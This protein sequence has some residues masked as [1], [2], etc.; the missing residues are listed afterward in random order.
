MIKVSVIVPVYNVEAYLSKCLETLVNQTLQEIEIIVVNDGTKDNSQAVIDSFVSKYN[1]VISLI[2]EN[3]GLS[4]ARNYGMQHAR[5]EYIGFVDSD[6]YTDTDMYEILYRKA[7]EREYDVVE[8]NLHHVYEDGSIDTEIGEHIIESKELLMRGRSVV[9]NKIYR[10]DWL[11]QTR[12]TFPKG[13]IYEDVEFFG[14]LVPH[15]RSY[16]YVEQAS[17]Y[18]V[19]RSNSINNKQTRK[20]MQIIDILEHIRSYYHDIHVYDEYKEAL[21]YLYAR[22]LLCSSFARMCR[23]P[24]KRERTEAL[25]SNWMALTDNFPKWHDNPYIRQQQTRNA[26][27]MRAMNGFTY[28]MCS[29]LLPLYFAHIRKV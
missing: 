18:Y 5:G 8:C 16:A 20:T 6:D 3:G 24:D 14:K 4:D 28:K 23:I 13:Y 22:I 11:E 19:Q 10:R 12:V 29:R 26:R 27:F 21:E 15:I 9:W 25:K 1:N 7:K 2:K 17:I